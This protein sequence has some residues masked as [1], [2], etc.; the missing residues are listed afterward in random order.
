MLQQAVVR[1]NGA[2]DTEASGNVVQET[3]SDG[4][5]LQ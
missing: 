1:I 2:L 3:V 4:A 5:C